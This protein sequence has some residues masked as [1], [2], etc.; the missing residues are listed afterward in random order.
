MNWPSLPLIILFLRMHY[1]H[2][3][4][5]AIV[6]TRGVAGI[7]YIGRPNGAR[8]I[9]NVVLLIRSSIATLNGS[10][11]TVGLVQWRECRTGI[12]QTIS[13]AVTTFSKLTSLIERIV[14]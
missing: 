12:G 11:D 5:L 9:W 8:S 14:P 6:V 2:S 1:Q 3:S 7:V 4:E 13:F 10:V